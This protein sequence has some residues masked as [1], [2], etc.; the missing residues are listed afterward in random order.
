MLTYRLQVLAPLLL[1][2]PLAWGVASRAQPPD[3]PN[4]ISAPQAATRPNG[5]PP[6]LPLLPLALDAWLQQRGGETKLTLKMENATAEQIAAEVSRQTGLNVVAAPHLL[7]DEETGPYFSVEATGQPFW[8][9]VRE[10]NRARKP[11]PELNVGPPRILHRA[12]GELG[13]QHD[14]SDRN[15]WML[16]TFGQ[17]EDG[18]VAQAGPATLR[19]TNIQLSRVRSRA[20]GARAGVNPV[21]GRLP[22]QERARLSIH[23][24][25]QIDPRLQPFVAGVIAEVRSATDGQGRAIAPTRSFSP[26]MSGMNGDTFL[27]FGL[28]EPAANAVVIQQLSGV[29][30]LAVVS[31]SEK[32]EID[33]AATPKAQKTFQSEDGE[34][35]L[36]FDGLVERAGS[37]TAQ[38]FHSR[39]ALPQPRVFKAGDG[40]GMGQS[41]DWSSLHRAIRLLDAEGV[42]LPS[43]GSSMTGGGEPGTPGISLD[44]SV[45]RR[46]ILRR[47][48]VALNEVENKPVAPP[49][50]IVIDLPLEWREVQIPFEIK[51]IPLP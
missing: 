11:A 19:A 12:G 3:V 24:Q 46:G 45:G 4:A 9:A 14:W 48:G 36:R 27:S 50:K 31:R 15:R 47:N 44:L 49:A 40:W 2:A 33:T 6:E 28:D 41:M 35:T 42:A 29:L 22:E 7:G 34:V 18:I 32:W 8:Q 1:A 51:D 39:K 25:L 37:W 21:P 43:G 26:P 38:F 10:W 17:R 20:L 30:R 23:G 5:R 13:L 16:S